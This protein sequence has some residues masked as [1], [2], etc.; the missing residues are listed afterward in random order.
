MSRQPVLKPAAEVEILAYAPTQF[1]HCLHCEVV[2]SGLKL[3]SD[4][5]ADQGESSLPPE[6]Q[7]EY[8]AISAWVTEASERY[9]QR[10]KFTIVDAASIQGLVKSVRHRS[11]RF[12]VFVINGSERFSGF[13]R[14]TLDRALEN[15]LG[16]E[17][18]A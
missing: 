11:R 15:R 13:D 9:G 5:H 2:W 17:V 3:G 4:W 8:D 7:A 18:N 1:F 14:E 6:L 16:K 12:P 10:V